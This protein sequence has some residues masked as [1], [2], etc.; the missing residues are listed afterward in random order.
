MSVTKSNGTKIILPRSGPEHFWELI[1]DNFAGDDK[2]RWKYLAMLALRENC[3]WPLHWIGAVFGHPKGHVTRCLKRIKEQL[4]EH[5]EPEE[6]GE[7]AFDDA[8]DSAT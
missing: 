3:G 5:F 7:L 1:S 4:A 6:L 8:D 2:L